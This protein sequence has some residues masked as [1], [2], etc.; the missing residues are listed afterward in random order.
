MQ[1]IHPEDSN[2]LGYVY[3]FSNG[4]LVTSFQLP[5]Y[6]IITLSTSFSHF[7]SGCHLPPG[8]QVTN[9]IGHLLSSMCTM[10]PYHFNILLFILPKI[11][12]P[13]FSLI[14]QFLTF[15]SLEFPASVLQ[16]SISILNSFL[17]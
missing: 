1:F 9:H 3:Q 6:S 8:H 17:F 5:A 10:C 15:S 12:T 7:T 11:I 16:K 4:P 2:L 13:T 14:T